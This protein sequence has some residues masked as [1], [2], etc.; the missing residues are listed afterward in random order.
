MVN[1][2][3]NIQNVRDTIKAATTRLSAYRNIVS[4]LTFVFYSSS[5]FRRPLNMG[6]EKQNN[7]YYLDHN[8]ELTIIHFHTFE[9]NDL[10]IVNEISTLQINFEQFAIDS[11][12]A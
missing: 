3:D 10:N 6:V 4:E 9:N 11:C 5:V 2:I 1:Y 12:F 7:A 8:K